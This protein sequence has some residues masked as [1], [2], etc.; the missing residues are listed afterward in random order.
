MPHQA[1]STENGYHGCHC[2]DVEGQRL[3]V[4]I[5]Q[6]DEEGLTPSAPSSQYPEGR[7]IPLLAF[8]WTASGK[9][10][11]PL[12][13]KSSYNPVFRV[14]HCSVVFHKKRVMMFGGH[15]SIP[16]KD[17]QGT[18]QYLN[19]LW[20]LNLQK[21]AWS[22]LRVTGEPPRPRAYASMDLVG[23]R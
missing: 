2:V 19:D 10:W 9:S 1:L 4:M 15:R 21:K 6:L 13:V 23:P 11:T 12:T 5:G 18:M 22:V 7:S 16:G 14:G 17:G 8:T 20:S 3:I